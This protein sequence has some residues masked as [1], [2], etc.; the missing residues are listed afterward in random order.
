MI[1]LTGGLH[2]SRPIRWLDTP[3]I[4]PTP[5]RVREAVFNILGG[6]VVDSRCWDLCC[7]SGVMGLEALSRGARSVIFVDHNKRSLAQVKDNLRQLD[8]YPQGQTVVSELLRFVGSQTSTP[9]FIYC[10]PPYESGLYQPLLEALSLLP[11]PPATS[12]L[13]LEYRKG[14]PPWH[15]SGSWEQYDQ[16]HYGDTCLALLKREPA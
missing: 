1:K 13:L 16:R 7:G 11:P 2:R 3:T 4:R 8:L 12:T 15:K 9:D 6:A 14:T 10:D 5:A